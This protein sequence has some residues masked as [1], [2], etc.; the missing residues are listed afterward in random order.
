MGGHHLHG[1][2]LKRRGLGHQKPGQAHVLHGPGNGAHIARILGGCSTMAIGSK[3]A[4]AS[5]GCLLFHSTGVLSIRK[6]IPPGITAGGKRWGRHWKGFGFS[7]WQAT[8]PA[9]LLHASGGSRCGGDPGRAAGGK[10][11]RETGPFLPNGLAA[12]YGFS[13]QRNKRTSPSISKPQTADGSW[14]NSWPRRMWWSTLPAGNRRGDPPRVRPPECRQPCPDCSRRIGVR[15]DRSLRRRSCFDASPSHVRRHEHHRLPRNAP[16][17]GRRDLCGFSDGGEDGLRCHAGP[18]RTPDERPGTAC[19]Y[20]PLRR[21]H[22]HDGGPWA[23]PPNTG[24]WVRSA[25]PSAIAASTPMWEAGEPG[26][27]TSPSISSAMDNGGACAG[28]WGGRI[29]WETPVFGTT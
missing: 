21:G 24:S 28:S 2:V 18:L 15:P 26:T 6:T 13:I 9:V 4:L 20:R 14:T 25:S 19:G 23:V 11:D 27:G 16:P 17:E 10:V 5:I 3:V 22:V 29:S 8:S 7:I 1:L 12:T